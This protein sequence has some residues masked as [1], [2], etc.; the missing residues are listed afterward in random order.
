MIIIILIIISNSNNDSADCFIHHIAIASSDVIDQNKA[1][2]QC[3]LDSE[4]PVQQ[5]SR[6]ISS[7]TLITDECFIKE[8]TILSLMIIKL[9][10]ALFFM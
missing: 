3:L 2:N 9:E 5:K 7:Q 10:Y 1:K 8:T 6:E 4:D